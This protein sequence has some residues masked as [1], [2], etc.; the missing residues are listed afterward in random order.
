MFGGKRETTSSTAVRVHNQAPPQTVH[1]SSAADSKPAPA[2]ATTAS[3]DASKPSQA[4]PALSSAQA[5]QTSHTSQASQTSQTAKPANKP[6]GPDASRIISGE[7]PKQQGFAPRGDG[8][9]SEA[10][11]SESKQNT[12]NSGGAVLSSRENRTLTVGRSIKLRGEIAACDHL[13]VEGEVDAETAAAA[14]LE[15]S[16]E[17]T[18]RGNATV[19]TASITGTFEGKLAVKGLLFVESGGKVS[20]EVTCGE[21][22]VRRGGRVEGNLAYSGKADD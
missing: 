6:S 4:A 16:R 10:R 1:P 21:L 5:S 14:K 9:T 8:R 22:E 15:I 3:A 19:D 20:G 18:V 17:G 11:T 2:Q 7:R 13:I 12:A